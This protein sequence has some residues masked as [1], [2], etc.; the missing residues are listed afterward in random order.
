MSQWLGGG[1]M[2]G[3]GDGGVRGVRMEGWGGEV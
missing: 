1:Q 2:E 3:C